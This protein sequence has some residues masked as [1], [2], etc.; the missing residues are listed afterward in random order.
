MTTFL[1][2]PPIPS[3]SPLPSVCTNLT[4][5]K[6]PLPSSSAT[7]SP[8]GGQKVHFN[9]VYKY[10]CFLCAT[11]HCVVFGLSTGPS[12]IKRMVTGAAPM[13]DR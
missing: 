3:Y 11:S 10:V 7:R 1:N 4:P 2:P 9:F 12:V 6:P 13:L 8:L 5:S